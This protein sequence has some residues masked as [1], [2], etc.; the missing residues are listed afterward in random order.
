MRNLLLIKFPRYQPAA[1]FLSPKI[2]GEIAEPE[3]P[4]LA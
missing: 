2:H 1:S 4:V 3:Q